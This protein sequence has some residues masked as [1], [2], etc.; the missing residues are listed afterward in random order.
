GPLSLAT[1]R[2][3]MNGYI[4]ALKQS[5]IEIDESLIIPY[6]HTLD[7]VKV[8]IEELM[9]SENPPDGLFAFNDPVAI[10]AIQTIKKIGLRIPE[11]I[12]IVGFSNDYG[13]DL[14]EPNLTTIA[15]PTRLIGNTAM[16]LLFNLM[17]KDVSQW[18]AVTKTL[19]AELIIRNS[20]SGSYI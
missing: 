20:T 17:N 18:K 2:K 16:D 7:N 9:Q 4:D 19:D 14:I 3:R 15:Q 10:Q 13:S 6:E 12:G 1:S 5:K 11:D 8:C